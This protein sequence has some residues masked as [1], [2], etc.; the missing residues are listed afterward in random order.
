V[1]LKKATREDVL[2]VLESARAD[3]EL[4]GL[5]KHSLVERYLDCSIAFVGYSEGIPGAA[6]GIT[7]PV[8]FLEPNQLWLATTSLV[9]TNRYAFL[10]TSKNFVD[11]AVHNFGVVGGVVAKANVRSQRWLSWLGFTLGDEI[12]LPLLGPA[13]PFQKRLD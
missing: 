10:R 11:W 3:V 13:Y 6:W 7:T 8:N 2:A 9:E 12:D 5:N 1:T 4:A